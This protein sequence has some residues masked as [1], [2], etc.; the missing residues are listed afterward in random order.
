MS[1]Y[2]ESPNVSE[3]R[4]EEKKNRMRRAEREFLR[5]LR[6][7]EKSENF[8]TIKIIG[9]GAFGEVKLVQRKNDGKTYAL[10]SLI[11]SEMVSNSLF[12][13]LFF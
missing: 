8:Q 10:K 5:F 9:K 13:A 6:T 11:K 7:K 2:L 3:K 12:P 4:K 1:Q